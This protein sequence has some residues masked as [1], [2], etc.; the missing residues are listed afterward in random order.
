MLFAAGPL[1]DGHLLNK[2]S[3]LLVIQISVFAVNRPSV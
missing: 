1:S 3:A 2:L